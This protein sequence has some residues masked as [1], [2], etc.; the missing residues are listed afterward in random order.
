MT[1]PTRL[2][3][4]D[5]AAVYVVDILAVK[6]ADF[7]DGYLKS[8]AVSSYNT[9]AKL[10]AKFNTKLDSS[11]VSNYNTNAKLDAKFAAKVD[12]SEFGTISYSGLDGADASVYPTSF[13]Q[14]GTPALPEP[15]R[16]GSEFLGWTWAGQGTPTTD[17]N[18]VKNAFSS[19]GAVALTANWG[20]PSASYFFTEGAPCQADGGEQSH[21][22]AVRLASERKSV[23]GVTFAKRDEAPLGAAADGIR[24]KVGDGAA[25]G[26]GASAGACELVELPGG[27]WGV[28]VTVT[29]PA[30]AI[31]EA[32]VASSYVDSSY[33]AALAK[34]SYTF[35]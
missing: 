17:P 15:Q 10:D 4:G 31:D 35:A 21:T 6:K 16:D 33:V 2:D 22:I 30:G 19:A 11:A 18:V 27:G 26:W 12:A 9:N 25:V 20:A 13:R 32:R 29:V 8:A 5:N 28:Y 7:D 14:G 3:Y 1:R 24:F 34:M 23:T